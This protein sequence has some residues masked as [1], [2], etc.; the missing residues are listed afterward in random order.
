MR[1]YNVGQTDT[2]RYTEYEKGCVYTPDEH[3][4]YFAKH[5]LA[6]GEDVKLPNYKCFF[7]TIGATM[8]TVR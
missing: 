3:P 2:S 1:P 5:K 7:S 6:E 4:V 8:S